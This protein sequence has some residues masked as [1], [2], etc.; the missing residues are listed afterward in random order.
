M[1]HIYKSSEKEERRLNIKYM[2]YGV[3]CLVGKKSGKFKSQFFAGSSVVK[4]QACI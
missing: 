3:T 1:N 2:Q 4:I